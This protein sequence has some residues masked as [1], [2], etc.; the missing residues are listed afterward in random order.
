M[1]S[2]RFLWKRGRAVSALLWWRLHLWLSIPYSRIHW[3][4]L[5]NNGDDPEMRHEWGFFVLQ[6]LHYFWLCILPH[7]MLNEPKFDRNNIGI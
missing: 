6:H 2:W 7:L 1:G 5:A 4:D 3:R